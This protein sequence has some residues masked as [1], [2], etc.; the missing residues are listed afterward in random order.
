MAYP[1]TTFD[2]VRRLS[3]A[4]VLFAA[5]VLYG[6]YLH[7]GLWTLEIQGIHAWRQSATMWNVRNFVRY[8]PNIFNPRAMTM[9]EDG[10]ALI[11]RL[12]FPLLQYFIAGL[13]KV[14][15]EHIVLARAT[16][17]AVTV[18]GAAGLALLVRDLTRNSVA[19][20]LT[21]GLYLFAPALFYY[22]INPLPDLLALAAS[23][24][25]LYFA[26]RYFTAA[27]AGPRT[28]DLVLSAV[29]LGVA[30]WAKL[31][32][33]MISIV[34]IYF[35]LKQLVTRRP[36]V[37]RSVREAG[38]QLL[39]I[40]PALAWY[41]WVIPSWAASPTVEPSLTAI[42]DHPMA[43]EWLDLW[44]GQ[45]F[46]QRLLGEGR[47]WLAAV[48]VFLV[49][50]SRSAGWWLTLSLMTV[51]YYVLE[52][53]AIERVHDYYMLPFLLPIYPVVGFAVAYGLRLGVYA[54]VAFLLLVAYAGY[55]AHAL[56]AKNWT[57]PYTYFDEDVLGNSEALAALAPRDSLALIVRDLSANVFGYRVDKRGYVLT[58]RD[59]LPPG[60]LADYIDRQ[61]VSYL[62][63]NQA[64]I[65]DDPALRPHI[66][67]L[68]GAFGGVRVFRLRAPRPPDSPTEGR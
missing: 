3:Y 56:E 34:S 62:Y 2:S 33:L 29:A 13:Y 5:I 39:V 1:A 15:G 58:D 16:I 21:A 50:A 41:A 28:S 64:R 19:G 8:D 47:V 57:A 42:F 30:T 55:Q 67:S 54:E 60:W 35:F 31:P 61:G 26:V 43:A 40:A 45:F 9:A 20:A 18:A 59:T 24:W 52:F 14:F 32:Y 36:G 37:V 44:F 4:K 11:Q 6:V 7:W 49:F 48:G 38:L 65:N 10:R 17:Y 27:G 66:D 23:W 68:L 12:E 46:P 53:E 51:L 25:Y 63:S 22:S